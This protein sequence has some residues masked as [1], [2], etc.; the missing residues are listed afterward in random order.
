LPGGD[1]ALRRQGD[2]DQTRP[3][4]AEIN[5]ALVP[6]RVEDG[7]ETMLT[8]QVARQPQEAGVVVDQSD[9][10]ALDHRALLSARPATLVRVSNAAAISKSPIPTRA[11]F[12]PARPGPASE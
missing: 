10:R 6:Q 2:Q 8:E 1:R 4:E 9:Q 12:V 5:V 3:T 7:A 11:A